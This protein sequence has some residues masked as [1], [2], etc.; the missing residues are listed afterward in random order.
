MIQINED[1]HSPT[2]KEATYELSNQLGMS[3]ILFVFPVLFW[4][5]RKKYREGWGGIG[6]RGTIAF[7]AFTMV[8]M[9]YRGLLNA[10]SSSSDRDLAYS[11]CY[12]ERNE[13][14]DEKYYYSSSLFKI[15]GTK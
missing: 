7:V 10:Q 1:L 5:H 15:L 6:S 8:L 12:G 11:I 2:L 13:E 4:V 3:I 9:P 14:I